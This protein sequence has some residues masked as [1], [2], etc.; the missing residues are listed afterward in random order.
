MDEEG[1]GYVDEPE[2]YEDENVF[3]DNEMDDIDDQDI[4]EVI[5]ILFFSSILFQI[6]FVL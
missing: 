1:G 6:V 3:N 5:Y 4:Q 2:L